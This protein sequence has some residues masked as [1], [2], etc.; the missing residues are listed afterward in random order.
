MSKNGH[1]ELQSV[2]SVHLDPTSLNLN[3]A[4]EFQPRDGTTI[5]TSLNLDLVMELQ[6]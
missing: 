2:I 1:S 4:I 3:F 5:S 6:P